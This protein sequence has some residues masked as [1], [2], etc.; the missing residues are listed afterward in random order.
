M[1]S[2]LART[3]AIQTISQ[4]SPM[5]LGA[6]DPLSKIWACDVFNLARAWLAPYFFTSAAVVPK[7]PP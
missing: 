3:Q 2:N 5:D 6:T 7:K 4:R 1:S